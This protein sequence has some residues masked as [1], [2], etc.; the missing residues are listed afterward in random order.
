LLESGHCVLF[1]FSFHCRGL[2]EGFIKQHI[3]SI[4]SLVKTAGREKAHLNLLNCA[5]KVRSN[6]V[7]L[8]G[9]ANRLVCLSL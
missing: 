8:F 6:F 2:R 7:E 5:R 9:F 4:T 3:L 1:T